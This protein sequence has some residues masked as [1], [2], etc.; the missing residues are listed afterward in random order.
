M[1]PDKVSY[2][3]GKHVT[4]MYQ[5]ESRGK[6]L[7]HRVHELENDEEVVPWHKDQKPIFCPIPNA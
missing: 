6:M 4:M 5:A 2:D 7:S 3:M 1:Q